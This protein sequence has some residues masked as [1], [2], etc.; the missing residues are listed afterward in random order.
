[1]RKFF[2][3]LLVPLFAASC[4]NEI[5]EPEKS[6]PEKIE[7]LLSKK[8]SELHSCNSPDCERINKTKDTILVL[9]GEGNYYRVIPKYNYFDF[10]SLAENLSYHIP[11]SDVLDMRVKQDMN[12]TITYTL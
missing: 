5:S 9:N 6:G 7:L 10:F 12:E 8:H 3:L 11:T 1:M 4:S 2:F